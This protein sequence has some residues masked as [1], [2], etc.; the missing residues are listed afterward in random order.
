MAMMERMS[1]NK[2][3]VDIIIK[4]VS[5]ISYSMSINGNMSIPFK[6]TRGLRQGDPLSLFF[7]LI[8]SEGLSSL[9]RLALKEG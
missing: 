1:F 6:G 2:A 7:F 9:T 4:C 3:W 8:Y 5:T